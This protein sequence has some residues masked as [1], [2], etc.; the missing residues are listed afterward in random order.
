[1][2]KKTVKF[3]FKNDIFMATPLLK[4]VKIQDSLFFRMRKNSIKSSLS[5]T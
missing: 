2:A 1:M 4:S 3:V 5:E